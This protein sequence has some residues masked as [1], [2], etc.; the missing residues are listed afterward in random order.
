[1]EVLSHDMMTM[2]MMEGV[3]SDRCCCYKGNEQQHHLDDFGREFYAMHCSL[4]IESSLPIRVS[5]V[6]FYSSKVLPPFPVLHC[7]LHIAFDVQ[8]SEMGGGGE[9][10][11]TFRIFQH[12]FVGISTK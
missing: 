2:M 11:M 9:I 4:Y 12:K 1:M 5:F 10:A 7:I 8:W 3:V 6:T